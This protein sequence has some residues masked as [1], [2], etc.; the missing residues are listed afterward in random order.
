MSIRNGRR[1]RQE[2][3]DADPAN[4]TEWEQAWKEHFD[5]HPEV[6]ASYRHQ[7]GMWPM[8]HRYDERNYY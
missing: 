3:L 4:L 7:S 1:T 2:L 5:R 8:G 6:V